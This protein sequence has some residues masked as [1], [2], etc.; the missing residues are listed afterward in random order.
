MSAAAEF[1]AFL[2]GIEKRAYAMAMVSLRNPDDALDVVQDAMLTLA[3]K[4]AHKAPDEWRPL[5][6]R[7]LRNRLTDWHRSSK[8]RN[9]WFVRNFSSGESDTTDV[10]D[11]APAPEEGSPERQHDAELTRHRLEDALAALPERQRE[12]FMFRAWEGMSVR[13]TARAMGCSEG[14]VKTHY[15]RAVHALREEL[16][17][18]RERT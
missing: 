16:E 11:T 14:S 12:A 6:Y 4:Y 3:S 15:S 13:E 17:E 1:N 10:V 8:V 2:A 7:I 18:D 5:F 9:R